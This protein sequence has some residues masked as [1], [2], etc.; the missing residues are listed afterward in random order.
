MRKLTI[1][2]ICVFLTTVA[3]QSPVQN[4]RANENAVKVIGAPRLFAE[5]V[6]STPD[7]ERNVSFTADGKIVF[8][9]KRSPQN[10]YFSAICFSRTVGGKWREPQIAGFSGRFFDTDPYVTPDG[11][12][13]FFASDRPL[14]NV[15]GAP[16]KP[17]LDIWVAERKG[18][19]WAAP[20]R[21]GTNINTDAFENSPSVTNGGTLY[22]ASTRAGGKGGFDIY[23]AKP[24]GNDFAPAENLGASVNT[25]FSE[26]QS[27]VTPDESVLLFVSYLRPDELRRA[28]L[29]YPRGDIYLARRRAGKW[30]QSLHL[31]APINSIAG[32]ST[33]F[34]SPN[35]KNLYFG[36]E[37]NFAAERLPKPVSATEFTR[38]LE[39]I[40]NGLGNIYKVEIEILD[41]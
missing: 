22:F 35:K 26:T 37:R 5:N 30:S 24:D 11:A 40:E 18:N 21:L 1:L 31:P 41:E 27:Y 25:E 23:A 19:D 12:K 20:V 8:F 16:R 13:V 32:E 39:R 17:D 28:D 4:S 36:S 6:V 10:P 2:V 9:T 38:R 34:L 7:N 29:F 15:D 14:S 33:P 3:G